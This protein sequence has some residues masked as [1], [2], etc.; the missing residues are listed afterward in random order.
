MAVSGRKILIKT[1]FLN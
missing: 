1:F